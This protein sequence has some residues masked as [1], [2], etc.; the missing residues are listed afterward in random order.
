MK[1]SQENITPR[2]KNNLTIETKKDGI[3]QLG[4]K[5]KLEF[6]FYLHKLDEKLEILT[7]E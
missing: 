3:R 6:F 5:H 1:N 2:E 4:Y 7:V